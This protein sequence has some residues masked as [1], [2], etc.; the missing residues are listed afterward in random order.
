MVPKSLPSFLLGGIT[1]LLFGLNTLVWGSILLAFA[2]VKIVVPHAWIKHR[3]LKLL[4][5]IAMGWI[6]C[7]SRIIG[8]T[9]KVDWDVRGIDGLAVEQSCLVI[10]NHRSWTDI[11]VL[12]HVLKHRVPFFRFFLKQELIWVPIIG[13]AC[14]ALDFPFLK[15]YSRSFLEKHPEMRGKDMQTTRRHCER[16]K[17]EPV[18]I[19]NFVE[20]TRFTH[21]KHR[22]QNAAYRHLLAPKAGGVALVFSCL[23]DCLS[24]VVDLT[25]VYPD[26]APPVGFWDMLAG[27]IRRIVVRVERLPVPGNVAGMNYQEDQ[28][29]RERVRKWIN[30]LWQE[31]DQRIEALLA[32]GKKDE[33]CPVCEPAMNSGA[34]I[35]R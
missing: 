12:L 3:I 9:R 26:N 20:G 5:F 35:R 6:E 8:M 16:Y 4:I 2:L 27:R 15:R 19:V 33:N 1:L 18:S 29:F 7:N 24:D 23:G 25:I 17:T 13:Q 32:E 22:R 14:R 21:Q 31:K 30:R 10:C 34:E 11:F 28:F